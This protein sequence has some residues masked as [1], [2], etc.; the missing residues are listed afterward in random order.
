MLAGGIVARLHPALPPLLD[1]R[2]ELELRRRVEA[3]GA[4]KERADARV[5]QA[6]VALA[7][8]R[9]EL[10]R[11]RKLA[12][13]AVAQAK[14]ESDELTFDMSN[15]E[16]ESARAEA[17]VALHDIE[18]ATAALA[19]A[20]EGGGRGAEAEWLLRAPVAGR[21]LRVQQKS[22]GT[23]GVGYGTDRVGRSAE[24]GGGH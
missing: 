4:A 23:V 18:I 5:K 11:S 20:R 10:E 24:P 21:V 6:E 8:N 9:V 16:L 13:E 2:T 7:L 17:H 19:R 1:A 12:P 22:G 3:A 15:R 14:L